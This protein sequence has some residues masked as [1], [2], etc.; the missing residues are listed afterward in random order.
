MY[1]RS[2]G[3]QEPSAA[4]QEVHRKETICV[5]DK[6]GV[7]ENTAHYAL[8]GIP[9]RAY[10]VVQKNEFVGSC[11][12]GWQVEPPPHQ[13]PLFRHGVTGRRFSATAGTAGRT[14]QPLPVATAKRF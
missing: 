13:I 6:T 7:V 11:D 12:T 2:R 5:G 4:A 1:P 9:E 3:D 10:C 14:D 8:R